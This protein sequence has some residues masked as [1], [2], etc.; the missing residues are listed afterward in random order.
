MYV[1]S[2]CH[3][4]YNEIYSILLFLF[5]YLYTQQRNLLLHLMKLWY[6]KYPSKEKERERERKVF[7]ELTSVFSINITYR[8]KYFTFICR[9]KNP[10]L[11]ASSAF[12]EQRN[13]IEKSPLQCSTHDVSLLA[14]ENSGNAWTGAHKYDRSAILIFARRLHSLRDF[15]FRAT[16]LS[17]FAH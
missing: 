3:G 11:D 6:L 2:S 15:H 13:G 16:C 14:Q 7:N 4:I 8:P 17:I 1:Q 12:L 10:R 5:K 9:F